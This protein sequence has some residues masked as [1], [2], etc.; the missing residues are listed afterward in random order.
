MS[1]IDDILGRIA[2][3]EEELAQ[4]LREAEEE[5]LYTIKGR[6]VR[7]S[8]QAR[9]LHRTLASRWT[10]YV[11]DSGAL[12]ILTIPVIWSALIPALLLDALVTL[13]QLVCFPIYG[14]PRVRRRDYVI[15]DRHQLAYLNWIEKLN[16]AYC[17]YF[18][19]LMGFVAEVAARTEQYWCPIRH[20]RLPRSV[21]SRYRL[22]FGYGDAKAYKDGLDKVRGRFDDVR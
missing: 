11:H 16:C 1:R 10:A 6:K 20:A 3:L 17:S 14:I 2:K 5:L 19:G 8:E 13:F 4:E 9:A 21:H 18:N 22:F 12:I 15:F 7:F